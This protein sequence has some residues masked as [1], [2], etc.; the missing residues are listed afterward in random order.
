ML[1]IISTCSFLYTTLQFIYS[2]FMQIS[3]SHSINFFV[4][5]TRHLF[6]SWQESTAL[7]LLLPFLPAPG[8]ADD[9]S[10]T[11]ISMMIL[12]WYLTIGMSIEM[13][14]QHPT[15]SLFGDC[16]AKQWVSG[17]QTNLS[18][19]QVEDESQQ[20]KS[21]LHQRNPYI[22]STARSILTRRRRIDASL[23]GW[24][25]RRYPIKCLIDW[26][27]LPMYI[28]TKGRIETKPVSNWLLGMLEICGDRSPVLTTWQASFLVENTTHRQPVHAFRQCSW[29]VSSLLVTIMQCL[30]I[31]LPR[32]QWRLPRFILGGM[33]KSP[34]LNP[35][36]KTQ[37]L[38]MPIYQW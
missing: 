23:S 1:S 37:T 16:P 19:Q 30:W 22:L 25:R 5:I 24:H 12:V 13:T 28:C 20:L 9:L 15:T 10:T 11:R 34:G 17:Q 3:I 21:L 27:R 33:R 38:H 7:V 31:P 2:T 8:E 6:K 29:R 35:P 18:R 26:I 36:R 32:M 4:P 14:F